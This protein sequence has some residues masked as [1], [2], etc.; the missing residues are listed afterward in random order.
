M[1]PAVQIEH[2]SKRYL[3]GARQGRYSYRTLRESI[4]NG[5]RASYRSLRRLFAR[6]A[7][8]ANGSGNELWALD[9]VSFDVEH[10]EVIGIIG[11]NGAGKS[12]LLKILSSITKPTSGLARLHG[13]VGSL[14]EVGTGFHP[15][16]TG[17]ENIY[18]AGA[19]LRM[20]RRELARK[21]DEIVAFSGIEDF[22]DTPVKR[23][24]SGM[25]VRLAFAVAAH[26]ESE[27]LIIDEVLAVGDI[28]FQKRCLN[29]MEG[30]ARS[31]RT[32]LFVS[33]NLAAV[34][35]L[36]ARAVL[37]RH[38]RVERIGPCA[39]TVQAYIRSGSSVEGGQDLSTAR[40]NGATPIIQSITLL[41]GSGTPATHFSCGSEL[42][43]A[44]RYKLPRP[45]V[46]PVI[47]IVVHSLLGENLFYLQTL[48]QY[49]FV[50]DLALEGTAR[51]T[52]PELALLPG[53]YK[54]SIYF[55]E[56]ATELPLDALER[57]VTL[58]VERADF[59]GTGQLPF[60]RT[61]H[62]LVRAQWS[63]GAPEDFAPAADSHDLDNA[64]EVNHG[65]SKGDA[66]VET[67]AG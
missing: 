61:G 19:I 51:C 31:G 12:T 45:V 47:G 25:Y 48:S 15:E 24:S 58:N 55:S 10:G 27:I 16:L 13:R 40:L 23:Y 62:V 57:A 44:I 5:L 56:R 26:L 22:L 54:L 39:E 42:T 38:G 63:F 8:T 3:L 17:R 7:G 20:T 18:L 43:V 37:L 1:T 14:L 4:G 28:D 53:A 49:G 9:D 21:F 66:G 36:C 32:V 41:D 65:A 50:E 67:R 2:L 6:P 35:H 29:K 46:G 64:S 59:F 34:Q 11:H 33:H 60:N 30:V 52:V